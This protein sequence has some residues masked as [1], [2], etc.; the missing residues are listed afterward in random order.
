MIDADK[1]RQQ[2]E[3]F[4]K[5]MRIAHR[6]NMQAIATAQRLTDMNADKIDAMH[7]TALAFRN[8]LRLASCS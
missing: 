1:E 5:A 4:L 2:S 3:A 6:Q 7:G 8:R